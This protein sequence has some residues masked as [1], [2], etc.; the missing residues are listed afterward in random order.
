MSGV[1]ILRRQSTHNT[2][3]L[4]TPLSWDKADSLWAG[5]YSVYVEDYKG[6]WVEGSVSL[7]Q[8]D[9]IRLDSVYTRPRHLLG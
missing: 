5:T 7:T 4:S 6:C 3:T 8:P 9:S 2:V 1:L